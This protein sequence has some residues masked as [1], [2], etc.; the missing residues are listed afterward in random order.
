MIL[1][2]SIFATRVRNCVEVAKLLDTT[3][4]LR[5]PELFAALLSKLPQT[6]RTRWFDYAKTN[7]TGQSK[8]E[9]FSDFLSREVD[10][11]L[12]FGAVAETTGM[13]RERSHAVAESEASPEADPAHSHFVQAETAPEHPKGKGIPVPNCNDLKIKFLCAPVVFKQ[14]NTPLRPL[15]KVIPVT[16][17]GPA[18]SADIFAL[19]DD[20]STATFLDTNIAQ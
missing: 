4:Y 6:S 13:H 9:L 15:L 19:L 8:I 10:L 1:K 5:S 14:A 3:D 7:Y 2:T 16:I 18:G 11:A 12:Q 20:G 17:F